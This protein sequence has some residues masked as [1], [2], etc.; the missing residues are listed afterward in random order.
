[1]DEV[2]MRI[3]ASLLTT[4][5]LCLSTMKMLGVLQQSGYKRDSFCGW[6][7]RKDNLYF[8]R[9]AVLSF[10]LALTSTVTALCFSFLGVRGA[11]LTASV[12]FFGLLL[13]FWRMDSKY[14]LKVQT[15]FTGRLR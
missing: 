9:L 10:C 6:L 11:L 7:K 4:L 12:P 8:N 5:L 3:I 15:R 13:L 1:M 2:M 14:A